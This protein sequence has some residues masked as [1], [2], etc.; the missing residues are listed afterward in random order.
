MNRQK[1]NYKI[2]DIYLMEFY[3]EGSE[4]K[5]VRPGLIFSNNTGNMFSPNIIA[6]PLTSSIKKVS[7][8]THVFLRAVDT[9]LKMDSL[10]L[11]ENPEKMSKKRIG[12]YITSLSLEQMA[13]VAEGFLLATSAISFIKQDNLIDVYH[14]AV[15]LNAT[16]V[17]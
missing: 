11:C 14:K 9:G 4:Q 6:L 10:V 8:P 17:A 7:Q 2:G 5:G 15:S 13:K 1:D 3:G 16:S 12:N